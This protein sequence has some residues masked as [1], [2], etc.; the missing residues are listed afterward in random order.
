MESPKNSYSPTSPNPPD[1]LMQTASRNHIQLGPILFPWDKPYH[2]EEPQHS[3][4]LQQPEESCHYEHPN[5]QEGPYHSE[6]SNYFELPNHQEEA[7]HN[8]QSYHFEQ[9][10]QSEQLYHSEQSNQS[11]QLYHSE[12]SNQSEQLYHS[13]GL[14]NSEEGYHHE[15][16]YQHEESYQ[17]EQPNLYEESTNMVQEEATPDVYAEFSDMTWNQ[18]QFNFEFQNNSI[19]NHAQVVH[20]PVH[21][22]QQTY[23]T[24][25]TIVVSNA[26]TPFGQKLYR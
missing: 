7:F 25:P 9:S 26:R 5:Q 16:T 13:E 24:E 21:E 17:H 18:N 1:Y 11:E 23:V 20:P 10:H 3:E 15:G 6:Q 8:Q 2:P 14:Y 19:D 4:E 12:Q 22:I